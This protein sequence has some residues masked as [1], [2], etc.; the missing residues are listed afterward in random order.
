MSNIPQNTTITNTLIKLGLGQNEAKLYEIMLSMPAATIPTLTQKCG[1]S[2]TMLYYVLGNLEAQ[3]L[4]ETK[5]DGK[6]TVYQVTPP[7]RLESMM[8][9]Q[10]KELARQKSVLGDVMIDL[11]GIYRMAHNQPGVRF[12]DGPDGI[13]TV[14]NII[15]KKFRPDTEIISFVKVASSQHTGALGHAVENFV[16]KR[17]ASNVRTRVLAIDS[18]DAIILK[19]NDKNALRET[20]LI[21]TKDLQLDFPGGEILIYDHEIYFVTIDNNLYFAFTVSS[22]GLA[23][24]LKAFFSAEWL[25]LS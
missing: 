11:K 14:F 13:A 24:M 19:E 17:I 16:H 2:R 5:K 6:K 18:P 25:L 21:S 23:Q 9:E 4:V 8:A 12:Y 22:P 7:E 1:L 20:R 15:A 10:E 3:E